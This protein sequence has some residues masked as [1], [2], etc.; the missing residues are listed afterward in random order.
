VQAKPQVLFEHT[1]WLFAGPAGQA[2]PQVL[3]L[4]ALL[5]VSTQLPLHSDSEPLGQPV[6]H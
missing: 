4:L 1:G 6:L 2:V 3:Q 5:L